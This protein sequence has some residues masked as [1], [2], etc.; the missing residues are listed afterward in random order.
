MNKKMSSHLH[1][2]GWMYLVAL[3]I[4]AL[5][6]GTVFYVISRPKYNETLSIILFSENDFS[7]TM[8]TDISDNITHITSQNIT[9]LL[10]EGRDIDYSLMQSLVSA[11]M[12]VR[13][14]FVFPESVLKDENSPIGL[15]IP[16][17]EDVVVTLFGEMASQMK[18]YHSEDGKVYGIYLND[19]SDGK[20]NNFERLCDE[21]TPYIVLFSY[22]S[23]NL[24]GIYNTGEPDDGAA[25]D[26]IKYLLSESQE[27]VE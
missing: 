12:P 18:F 22:Y 10:V 26:I 27:A 21:D 23:F 1:Y 13:D 3:L 5:V 4:V 19:P 25:I 14:L 8:R 15:F 2:R 6:W 11:R 16:I 20:I 24:N 9:D 17:N 7:D